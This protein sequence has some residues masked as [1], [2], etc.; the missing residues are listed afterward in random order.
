MRP[1]S[2]LSCCLVFVSILLLT[3]C[4][5]E[6]PGDG[7]DEPAPGPR[8]ELP[9]P[10]VA[11]LGEPVELRESQDVFDVL[12]GSEIRD[13]ELGEAS[14]TPL[15]EDARH[16]T[17]FERDKD[18][19]PPRRPPRSKIHPLVEK[20]IQSRSPDEREMFV[21]TLRDD[22][23]IPRFPEAEVDA[24][25]DSEINRRA[26]ARAEEIVAEIREKRGRDAAMHKQLAAELQGELVESFWLVNAMTAELPMSAVGRLAEME[27]VLYIEPDQTED[28][29]PQDGSS[30]NDV[31]DARALLLSDPYFNA[32]LAGGW[33]G[34]LDTG[35]RA[36]HV[37]FN[38]PDHL[39]FLRDCVN[40]GSNC[41]SGGSLNTNDDCWNHGTR[42][43]GII[44]GNNRSGNAFRGVTEVPLDS[45]KVYP[46]TFSGGSCTGSLNT[47]ATLRGF[48]RA[49]AVLDRVVV[50]EMQGSG[51]DLSSI[52]QAADNAFDAGAIVIAANGN[53]GPGAETVNAPAN[54][55]RVIGIGNFDITSG[56]QIN[57]Q[58]RGPTDDDR[59]KPDVQM[60]T[61]TETASNGC[62]FGADCR[63]IGS[64]T[65]LATYGGT[66]GATPYG[67]AVAML[68]RNWM[69]RSGSIDPGHVY[70]RMILSGQQPYPFNNTSGAGRVVMPVNGFS[71]WGKAR[72]HDGET[73]DIPLNVTAASANQLDGAIWWPESGG[74]FLFWRTDTHNDVDLSL[75]SPSGSVIDS[76]ISV[77]SVF[78]RARVSGRVAT[79]TWKLR[80]RGYDVDSSSQIVYYGATVRN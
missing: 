20:W 50:A 36:T 78:E 40:G 8:F 13:G 53:N 19:Q 76:S 62:G 31:D 17:E 10:P 11:K 66:S 43:A 27:D 44:T 14:A 46:S 54:A 22:L 65:A 26:L 4:P 61:N 58:S 69:R 12:Y 32:G 71:W 33:I 74:R 63:G 55:H 18:Y 45:W 23:V 38:S 77:P 49:V 3:G 64:D 5:P 30:V 56:N 75:V 80:I 42:S 68:F 48:Q 37:Q 70:A 21:V 16:R 67:G 2:I 15:P 79:G 41:N 25:R 29:P 57:S 52:S 24:P 34:L 47:T 51:D 73:I 39:A 7:K 35:V 60:P 9:E 28:Y 1:T 72:I 59:F 6:G